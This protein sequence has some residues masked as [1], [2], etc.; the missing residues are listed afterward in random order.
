MIDLQLLETQ[1]DDTCQRL[2]T[3]GVDV[4]DV[5]QLR[6]LILKRRDLVS[7][8]DPLRAEVNALSKSVG[9]LM[10]EGRSDE[11]EASKQKSKELQ[12]QVK[13]A[14]QNLSETEA[15]LKDLHLRIP[16]L[17]DQR[18]PVG[19][20]EE[21]NVVL[22]HEGYDPSV[23]EGRIFKPHWE[24]A[25]EYDLL[26]L[27]RASKISGS[28][29]VIFKN[30]GA[31]LLRALVELALRRNRGTY[32]EIIPPHFVNSRTFTCTGHLPKFADD[33]Y[34]L[35]VDD[36]WA[37]PTG[38]VPLTGL[39]TGE[40]LEEADL[41]KRYMTYTVCFRREAGAAGKDTR[42]LMRLHEF[43][44]VELLHICSPEMGEDEFDLLHVNAEGTLKA[45]GL[46]YRV[47]DLCTKD[48]T[49][50]SA[51]IHD[52]E[53]YAPGVAK[54]LEASSVGNFT[55]FQSRRG[56]IRYRAAEDRKVRFAYTLNGSGIA[57]PR[58]W[59]AVVEHGWREGGYIE[60]PEVLHDI[61]GTDR[62]TRS[63]TE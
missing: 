12:V 41:P 14:E 49:F 48:L 3:K 36:L 55:D 20:G 33:A 19:E 10:K 17:P 43:H 54:W 52:L 29:F 47:V 39:H 62:I 6:Y 56:S 40:I 35:R 1:F 18:V 13:Q 24:I 8:L 7:S 22:R 44:K 32:T 45:L 58:V 9:K 37:I 23:Y 38:E 31:Q 11:A 53:V 15:S 2:T 21:D 4:Q 60:L 57:I 50:S 61:M 27:Q 28:M 26:D 16:N 63:G 34:A 25:E 46:P 59:A 42:G 5:Q 30:Q 51:R